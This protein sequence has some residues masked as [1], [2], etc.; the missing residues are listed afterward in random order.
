[1]PSKQFSVITTCLFAVTVHSVSADDS[2]EPQPREFDDASLEFFEK[3]VRPLLVKRCYECHSADTKEPKGGLRLDSRSLIL[4]GG[5]TG[6]AMVPSKPGDSLLVDAI[7]YGEVYQMP[8]KSKLP[9][10]EIATLTKWVAMGAPWPEEDAD[11]VSSDMEFDLEERRAAHWCWQPIQNPALPKVNKTDWP[12]QAF[13]LF[14]LAKLEEKGLT[15]AAPADRRTLVRRAY[16]DL[17][18][19]PPSSEEVEAFVNDNSLN[20]FAKV[21]DHLL[22][23]PHFGERWARHWMDLARYAET[24]GH[25]FDYSLPHAYKYRDYLIRAFNADVPFDQLVVEHV[26]GDLLKRA[27]NG[28]LPFELRMHP[29]EDYNESQIA[30]GFWW[31]GEA[32]HAPVDVRANEAERIDNQLD[33]FG[34][35][36]LGLTIGCARCHDHKFDAISTKDY[37]A[38]SGFMQSSRRAELFEG[39]F[40]GPNRVAGE[41][42]WIKHLGGQRFAKALWESP[43]SGEEFAR[44]LSAARDAMFG[45]LKGDVAAAAAKA[46]VDS[47]RL[48]AWVRALQSDDVKQRSHPLHVWH[49]LAESPTDQK[50][51]EVREQIAADT[52]LRKKLDETHPVFSDFSYPDT[53]D[54]WSSP[55]W[56]V[57]GEAFPTYITPLGE[58]DPQRGASRWA[59]YGVADSSRFGL[60]F[61][62][63]M[64]SKTFVLNHRNIYY[65]AKGRGV[66]IRLILDGY[67]M[68]VYNGLLFRGFSFDLKDD[69]RLAW[70]HQG[71]DIGRYLGHRAYIEILDHGD[72]YAALDEI[73][74]SNEGP[75][76]E[77]FSGV[78]S[79]VLTADTNTL[80]GLAEHYGQLWEA[81]RKELMNFLD[82]A[83]KSS[84]RL[85]EISD[86]WM[87]E[88]AQLLDWCG[89]SGLIPELEAK[90]KLRL[91][92]WETGQK[93]IP[94]TDRFLGMVDGT[95]EDERV[96]IRGNHKTLGP[97]APRRL[98]EALGGKP[99]PPPP[100]SRLGPVEQGS[101]RLQLAQELV[102]P[103]NPLTSRVMV[104][105]LWHHLFGRG[106]VATTDNFGVLGKRPTHPQ[107]LDHLATQF[108]NEGWSVKR[109]L[110]SL[111]L[112]STYQMASTPNPK[113]DEVDPNND[114][115]LRARIRRLQGEAIRDAMLAVSGRLDRK[116]HGPSVPIHITSFMQGRGRPG[117]SGPLDGNGRR[118]LYIETRRN[119]LSPMMLAFDTPIPFNAIGRRNVSN[120]PAQALILMNDPFVVQQAKTWARRAIAEV[121]EPEDRIR[122][123]YEAAFSRP[124]T[125]QELADAMAFVGQQ[126]AELKLDAEQL[127]VD[128]R[129][130]G[131]LCHVL[132]NVK[133]FVFVY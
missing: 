78:A 59:P 3:Q 102:D 62:G 75:P 91:K 121:P 33:V 122:K 18:G 54:I 120:V 14:I 98:L 28:H 117:N 61:Q 56:L 93:H 21:I 81:T 110:K 15:P 133:E 50:I 114:L 48:A 12:R 106:I 129:V 125:D 43:H 86:A 103:K 55:Q 44:Y 101:G 119:F 80:A 127:K 69:S 76:P 42:R 47:E 27:T 118:S 108:M 20:A 8:P 25:E 79:R 46:K 30:T 112:S 26:A 116:L 107:L 64:R 94:N 99:L 24:Y 65:R 132:M 53:G 9:E 7:N 32:T 35:T 51:S 4:K 97:E 5:D 104:N 123:L 17:I 39:T 70:H 111:M 92:D 6:P 89:A 22:D 109:M 29:E 115:L 41:L 36:F 130:W 68:D 37:Y 23:S 84:A 13:D 71:G 113:G 10:A 45:E 124:P 128:E 63:A 11:A 40:G 52:E 131:D 90:L 85:S 72:G 82:P 88:Q 49:L 73:R 66:K 105:R 100:V 60:K 34:K 74:F 2:N 87:P 38:L 95:G 96:F 67:F 31:L 1:M 58:W 83:R 16:F 57:A 19:L 77:L 126:G